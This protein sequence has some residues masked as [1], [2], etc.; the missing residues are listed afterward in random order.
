MHQKQEVS[1]AQQ[2][3][4]VSAKTL[5]ILTNLDGDKAQE[6]RDHVH[7]DATTHFGGRPPI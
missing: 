6:R 2:V 7:G 5:F 3:F 1:D 4:F